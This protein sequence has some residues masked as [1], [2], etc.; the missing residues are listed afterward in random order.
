M[1]HACALTFYYGSGSSSS[2]GFSSQ[3]LGR[4]LKTKS[5]LHCDLNVKE[6]TRERIARNSVGFEDITVTIFLFHLI[7]Q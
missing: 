6:I 7:G 2:G 5:K 4:D 3:G 1:H